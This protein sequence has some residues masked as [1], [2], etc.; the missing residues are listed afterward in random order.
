MRDGSEDL[1]LSLTF[2]NGDKLFVLNMWLFEVTF[3]NSSGFNA[4]G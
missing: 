1:L 2:I 4:G 3:G